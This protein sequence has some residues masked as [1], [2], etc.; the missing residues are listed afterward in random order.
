MR[1]GKEEQEIKSEKKTRT[2]SFR[3]LV[4]HGKELDFVL[5]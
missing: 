2:I 4:G 5:Q 3:G 1:K